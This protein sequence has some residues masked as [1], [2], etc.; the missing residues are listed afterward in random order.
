[1]STDTEDL[2]A[3][4]DMAD[5]ALAELDQLRADIATRGR[6]SGDKAQAA[7]VFEA[8]MTGAFVQQVQSA[9]ASLL[10]MIDQYNK[11][12]PARQA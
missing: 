7:L 1:M 4:R 10:G 6:R 12:L 11:G 3:W 2:Q 9:T 5:E 8:V